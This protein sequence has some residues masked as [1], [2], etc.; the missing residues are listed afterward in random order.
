MK[1]LIADDHA[2]MREG[3]R[4]ILIETPGIEIAGEAA[5]GREVLEMVDRTEVELVLLDISMPGMNG[6]EVLRILKKDHPRLPVLIL[7]MFPEEQYAVRSLRAGASG[8]LTKESA[9]EELIAAVRKVASGGKYISLSLAEKI[10]FEMEDEARGL[11]H[12]SL[13]DREYEVFRGIVAGKT[14][15]EIA[16]QLALSVKTISTYRQ[17]IFSKMKMHTN[18]ELTR[19]AVL[20]NIIE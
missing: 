3:L 20:N 7:S 18:A 5:N 17:R 1:I 2:I 4:H 14:S 9:S 16:E 8:Y 10:A 13:S 11:P 12:E 6:L 19:Y 15:G